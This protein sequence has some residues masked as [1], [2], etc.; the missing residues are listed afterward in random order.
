MDLEADSL[1]NIINTAACV[2]MAIGTSWGCL[3]AKVNDRIVI[4]LGLIILTFGFAG[5][6]WITHDGIQSW[7]AI[8]MA[9]A[10]LLI[11]VGLAVS[12]LGWLARTNRRGGRE[13]RASDF[14]DLDGPS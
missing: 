4:K 6:A 7:D 1:L 2:V 8:A 12:F 5:H 11:N 13:R 14:V 9:R 10:Q 3:S